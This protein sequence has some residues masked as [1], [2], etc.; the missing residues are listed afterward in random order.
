MPI[1]FNIK[2]FGIPSS[3]LQAFYNA[4]NSLDKD[5]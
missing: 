5:L 1:Y 3:S 2:I 4:E